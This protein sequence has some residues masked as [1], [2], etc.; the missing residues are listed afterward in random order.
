MPACQHP[1]WAQAALSAWDA[2][3]AWAACLE[4]TSSRLKSPPPTA[5]QDQ[6]VTVSCAPTVLRILSTETRV[7]A[8]ESLP[9]LFQGCLRWQRVCPCSVS[10]SPGHDPAHRST[11][12]DN[13]ESQL[14]TE[15]G[16]RE[17]TRGSGSRQNSTPHNE[18]PENLGKPAQGSR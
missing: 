11:V 8:L 14:Q 17:G 13:L 6:W 16:S 5:L 1:L 15:W 9:T 2:L 4:S 18:E 12:I 10:P 3:P 7:S